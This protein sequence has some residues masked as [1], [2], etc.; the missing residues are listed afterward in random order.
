MVV[1]DSG[2]GSCRLGQEGGRE[3]KKKEQMRDIDGLDRQEKLIIGIRHKRRH[4]M[5]LFHAKQEP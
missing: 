3:K 1:F 4:R 2:G 5:D